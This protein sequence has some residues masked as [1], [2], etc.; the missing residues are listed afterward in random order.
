M[1]TGDLDDLVMLDAPKK[2]SWPLDTGAGFF[3]DVFDWDWI[4]LDSINNYLM[5][6]IFL[7]TGVFPCSLSLHGYGS[8]RIYRKGSVK[9]SCLAI[10]RCTSVA[11]LSVHLVCVD[12]HAVANTVLEIEGATLSIENSSFVACSSSVDGS[13]VRSHGNAVVHITNSSFQDS[14][15]LGFGG[16]VCARGGICN[17]VDTTFINCSSILGGGAIAAAEPVCM[18]VDQVAKTVL[19]IWNS[20][21]EGCSTAGSGGALY[22]SAQTS[23]M[24]V[25]ASEFNGCKSFKSGGAVIAIDFASVLIK[26]SRF[27][28]NSALG[29]GGGAL[30]S[31]NAY[32]KLLGITSAGN[33]ALAGGGGVILWQGTIP[34]AIVPWCKLGYYPD[35]TFHCSPVTCD[36]KCLL[37]PPGRFSEMQGGEECTFCTAGKFSSGSGATLCTDCSEG[38]FSLAIGADS[39]LSCLACI[40]GSFSAEAGSTTCIKCDSGM[41]SNSG[42][43]ECQ[44]C[45]PGTHNALSG[46]SA[47]ASCF[48]GEYAESPG[49]MECNLCSEGSYSSASG[50]V[51]CDA[52]AS[53]KYSMYAGQSDCDVC[54]AGLFSLGGASSCTSCVAGKYQTGFGM[55]H[56]SKCLLCG[57]G[58]FSS[59]SSAT[60]ADICVNCS[61][62]LYSTSQGATECSSLDMNFTGDMLRYPPYSKNSKN[63]HKLS[64]KENLEQS[65]DV[66]Q[67][68]HTSSSPLKQEERCDDSEET[69]EVF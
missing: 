47:C 19:T 56:E 46:A 22:C 49:W 36:S 45:D 55:D 50:T 11:F 9:I 42:S 35:P 32:F 68:V 43:S 51:V 31:S 29:I 6:D 18:A 8:S 59:Q 23:T 65:S 28:N 52:C 15:S 2:K 5:S 17:I 58:T 37:C 1:D 26:A 30:H 21:F 40:A 14:N 63:L 12:G 67:L 53:G 34:P 61:N 54:G 41:F 20:R 44:D 16:A 38:S 69:V 13:C 60:T 27:I 66:R 7:C 10:E 25:T 33:A 3:I 39:S 57:L 4:V 64:S 62:G 24:T 48:P